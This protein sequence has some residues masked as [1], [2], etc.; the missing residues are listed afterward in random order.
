MAAGAPALPVLASILTSRSLW[1][2]NRDDEAKAG[3]LSQPLA[4]SPDP[5][6][7]QLYEPLCQ[8]Q[9][10]TGSLKPPGGRRIDLLEDV[11]DSLQIIFADPYPRIR[12]R[13]LYKP[14][15]HQVPLTSCRCRVDAL[16]VDGQ[17]L[18]VN[19]GDA[20]CPE[21]NGAAFT[22]K[23]DSIA[24]Q[25]QENLLENSLIGHNSVGKTFGAEG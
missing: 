19:P 12:H 11:K 16:A 22:G 15:A 8:C 2:G 5:A 18:A 24:E 3:A 13:Y 6:A 14:D 9:P 25:V 20:V 21:L 23:L 4:F 17:Q 7:M 10:Q 1:L